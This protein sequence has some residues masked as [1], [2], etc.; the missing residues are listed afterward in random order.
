MGNWQ[1]LDKMELVLIDNQNPVPSS[2]LKEDKTLDIPGYSW[3]DYPQPYLH[4]YRRGWLLAPV[5]GKY[6]P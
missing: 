5:N 2:C 1:W 6:D 4:D 3:N